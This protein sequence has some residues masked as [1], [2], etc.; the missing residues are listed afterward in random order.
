MKYRLLFLALNIYEGICE[1]NSTNIHSDT[2]R[3]RWCRVDVILNILVMLDGNNE[4]EI[5]NTKC[6]FYNKTM[7]RSS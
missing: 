6:T 3:I 4:S 1:I 5:R 7:L 2:Q